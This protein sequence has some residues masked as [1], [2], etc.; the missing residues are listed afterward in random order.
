MPSIFRPAIVTGKSVATARRKRASLTMA[1]TTVRPTA[2]RARMRRSDSTSGS[3]GIAIG[4]EVLIR[5][6]GSMK[7]AREA[8]E[9]LH[10]EGRST[11]YRIDR[12]HRERTLQ[13]G[14]I[15]RERPADR[16]AQGFSWRRKRS[17]HRRQH[18]L[19]LERCKRRRAAR[20]ERQD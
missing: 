13:L 19:L 12:G 8:H 7:R 11:R 4:R 9:I 10:A 5:V 17:A 1:E 20:G 16:I 2:E 6:Q 3:S 15:E 18:L 14:G